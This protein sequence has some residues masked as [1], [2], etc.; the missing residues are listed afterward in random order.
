MTDMEKLFEKWLNNNSKLSDSSISKYC[1]A[2]RAI[3]KDMIEEGVI[4]KDLYSITTYQD[5]TALKNIICNN[6]YFI[7]KDTRGNRMYS[8]ALN[9][10]TNFL[11][12]M[13]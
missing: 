7:S 1:R 4:D 5:L 2:I 12:S 10:Y 13:N 8:V 11:K 3:S 6:K 9:H